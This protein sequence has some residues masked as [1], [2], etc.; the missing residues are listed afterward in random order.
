MF[1][2]LSTYWKVGRMALDLVREPIDKDRSHYGAETGKV[3]KLMRGVYVDVE[4][5]INAVVLRHIR[6]DRPLPVSALAV[7]R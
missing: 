5:G 1:A 7:R 2:C 3:V 4:D 6:A